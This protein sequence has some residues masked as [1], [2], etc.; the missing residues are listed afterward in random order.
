M[1]EVVFD[2][3]NN[4]FELSVD[5]NLNCVS[6]TISCDEHTHG[7]IEFVYCF[8]GTAFN[9][10]NGAPYLMKSGDMILIDKNDS[11]SI[12][13]KGH[14][15]YCDIMLKPVFLEKKIHKN[16]G[17]DSLLELDEFHQFKNTFK[18]KTLIHF[19]VEDQKKIEFLIK[20]TQDE[21]KHEKISDVSMERSA[22]CMVLTLIFRY[23][24]A[25]DTLSL[26][27]ELL[28]Y[29]NDHCDEHLAAGMIADRC[30]YSVEHFSRKFKKLAG[31]NFTQYLCECR[32][33][34]AKELL[35]NTGKTVDVILDESGFTSRGEFFQKFEKRF[36][37]TP[38]NLR[39]NQKS[40]L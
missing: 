19:S 16:S 1:R 36:G 14:I 37:E 38:L 4:K 32:L 12:F 34:K 2:K 39:K 28:D 15:N 17:F 31:K 11:H 13:P 7:Y 10:I 22:L 29:I 3:E 21:L 35:L 6:T 23:M 9:Y 24:T 20:A 18:P 26:N 40:V 27:G 8:S 30:S 33:N 25:E 5:Y